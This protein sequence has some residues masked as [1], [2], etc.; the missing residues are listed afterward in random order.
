MNPRI[1]FQHDEQM[2]QL[3]RYLQNLPRVEN[4]DAVKGIIKKHNQLRR[5]KEEN[6]FIN[7]ITR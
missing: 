6:F 3:E 1:F 7:I 2:D 5:G 4:S